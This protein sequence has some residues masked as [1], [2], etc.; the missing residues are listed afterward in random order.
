MAWAQAPVYTADSIVNASDYS[1]GPFAPNSVLSIFGVNLSWYTYALPPGDVSVVPSEL[2][3]VEVFVDDWPAPILYVSGPQIN[4][5][6]PS[7]EIAGAVTVRVV[8]EGVTG[9]EVTIMLVNAAPA[10]FDAGT[11]L[12]IAT[13]ADGTLLTEASPALPGEIIVVYATGLGATEPNPGPGEVPQAAATI[14]GAASLA[15]SLDGA[16]LPSYLIKYAGVTPGCVGLY[17]INIELPTSVGT[18]PVI[19]V[20]VGSQANSGTPKI[21]VQ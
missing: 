18:D 19:Q 1:Y 17:Q 11:G 12:A 21:A 20:A 6:I 10:L 13:H 2:S 4:F 3:D 15:V 16:V 14:I 7:N 8:R 5:L 9:P